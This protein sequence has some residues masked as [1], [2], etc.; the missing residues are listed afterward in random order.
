MRK[1]TGSLLYMLMFMGYNK[2]TDNAYRPI[3]RVV[4]GREFDYRS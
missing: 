4:N 1:Y 3:S 2:D